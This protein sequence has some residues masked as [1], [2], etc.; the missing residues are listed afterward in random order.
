MY[1]TWV[2]TI[3]SLWR[4]LRLSLRH[5]WQARYRQAVLP[6][7]HKEY[8]KQPAACVTM[9][10]PH[11]QLPV[12][13]NGR[14]R[15]HNEI[16]D[17]IVCD[18]CAKVCPVDCIEIEA[19]K[20]P[21]PIGYASDGSVKRLYAAKFNID[22]AKCCYCGLCTTVCPTECLTMTKTFDYTEQNVYDLIYL[23][24]NL[25]KQEAEEKHRL[26]L[27]YQKEKQHQQLL[28][29][30]VKPLQPKKNLRPKPNTQPSSIA[31]KTGASTTQDSLATSQKAVQPET[32][33]PLLPLKE[34]D[35]QANLVPPD[36]EP[37]SQ[38]MP[39][40]TGKARP[41]V[42]PKKP[43]IPTKDKNGGNQTT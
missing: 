13:D 36:P 39:K 21:E 38:S 10:Y 37:E 14:Y 9:Q 42:R 34:D 30:K 7:W 41:V 31:L 43:I 25:S 32:N 22:M 28:E 12:P 29:K 40:A 4:G 24:G 6:I 5:L 19:I 8:F 15:L 3:I 35:G 11:E 1:T 2:Y 17:C 23:F 20:S 16:E 26:W 18:K 27:Q 33:V